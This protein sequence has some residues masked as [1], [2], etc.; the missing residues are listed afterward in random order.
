MTEAIWDTAAATSEETLA[1]PSVQDVFAA[2]SGAATSK[3]TFFDLGSAAW[4]P[5]NH[6]TEGGPEYPDEIRGKV[7]LNAY[8]QGMSIQAIDCGA[9]NTLQTKVPPGFNVPRHKH[10][11]AQIVFVMQGSAFQGKREF[12]VGE[13][14]CTPAGSPYGIQAGPEGL[15][16]LEVRTTPL[17][18]LTTQWMETDP[19][20]WVHR[21]F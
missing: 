2:A 7:D 19:A 6:P 12:H 3:T 14:W 8:F 4:V 18:Q 17:S 9:Y 10:N 13:G 5:V 20:R 16:W 21:T 11:S 1:T 15:I